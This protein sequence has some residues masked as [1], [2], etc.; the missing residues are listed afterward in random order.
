MTEVANFAL[1]ADPEPCQCGCGAFG[2]LRAR[3]WRDGVR[4]VKRGCSCRR[5]RGSRNTKKGDRRAL[6]ARRALAIPGVGTRHEELLGGLV[7]WEA[8]AGSQIQPMWT[9]FLKAE[10]QSEQQRPFGDN[11][12]FVMSAAADGQSDQLV[13]FRMSQLTDVVAAL[14]EQLG[15]VA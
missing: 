7:R 1:K 15:L 13:A 4:C 9:A 2:Q 10:R 5:C 6:Q 12:P 3:A 8:K 14:A 11:R